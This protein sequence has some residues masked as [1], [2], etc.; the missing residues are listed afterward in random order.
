MRPVEL[1]PIVP[2]CPFRPRN[3][4]HALVWGPV[5]V[6]RGI[7]N[8]TLSPFFLN[9]MAHHMR[10]FLSRR[11]IGIDKIK[12]LVLGRLIFGPCYAPA[13]L[14]LHRGI[15]TIA[16][17]TCYDRPLCQP[18]YNRGHRF[19]EGATQ[20]VVAACDVFDVAPTVQQR[21]FHVAQPVWM[22]NVLNV[23]KNVSRKT[24]REIYGLI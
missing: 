6:T 10:P 16:R 21:G 24:S 7:G 3:I 2:W 8:P 12:N 23:K 19:C 11:G 5:A 1:S 14:G 17:G 20:G 22:G 15:R 9:M 4:L 13:P 18:L